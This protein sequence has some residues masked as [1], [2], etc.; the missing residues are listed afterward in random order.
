MQGVELE[1]IQIELDGA[2]GVRG[3][4]VTEIVG[5]LVW[6]QVV[7]FVVEVLAHAPN[8][9][10][11]GVDGLGLQALE[12]EVFKVGL[13][14]LI[15]ISAG[16]GG[17][18]VDVPSRMLQNHPNRIEGAKV[19]GKSCQGAGRLLRVAASSNPPRKWELPYP[20]RFASKR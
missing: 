18:H 3:D 14:A 11:V 1:P 19:Q 13:V 12:L 6:R 2:P 10:R 5:Q 4:Q 17:L 7:N 9:T 15:K 20:L 16:A 8:A